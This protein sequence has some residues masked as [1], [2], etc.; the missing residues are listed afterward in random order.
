VDENFQLTSPEQAALSV[1]DMSP[2]VRG[3]KPIR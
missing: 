2:P 1:I 3:L